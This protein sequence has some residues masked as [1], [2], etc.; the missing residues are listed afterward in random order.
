MVAVELNQH[1]KKIG[2]DLGVARTASR[3]GIFNADKC[4]VRWS[5]LHLL[6]K[7]GK[8]PEYTVEAQEDDEA[9][10]EERPKQTQAP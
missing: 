9:E 5:Y 6:R 10:E 7:Q 3:E 2:H 4:R 8:E 1:A